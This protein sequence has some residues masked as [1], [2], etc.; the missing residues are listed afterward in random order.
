MLIERN[1]N[2]KESVLATSKMGNSPKKAQKSFKENFLQFNNKD[3]L[4][5]ST[6]VNTS[7]GNLPSDDLFVVETNKIVTDYLRKIL[8]NELSKAPENLRFDFLAKHKFSPEIR[9]RMVI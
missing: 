5:K 8:S 9:A 2:K 6:K 4:M 3:L 7:D 1:E